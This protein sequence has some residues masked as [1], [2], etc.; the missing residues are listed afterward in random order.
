GSQ[1]GTGPFTSGNS[2]APQAPEREIHTRKSSSVQRTSK[3]SSEKLR[4]M[5]SLNSAALLTS[6]TRQPLNVFKATRWPSGE[7]AMCVQEEDGPAASSAICFWFCQSMIRTTLESDETARRSPRGVSR[8]FI[9]CPG[10]TCP[11]TW[12][13]AAFCKEGSRKS[14]IF[15]SPVWNA[16][17]EP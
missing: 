2:K 1:S 17:T 4:E 5:S 16:Q 8:N 12:R 13:S 9:A 3:G 6:K 15:E 10:M 7:K 14:S 11:G